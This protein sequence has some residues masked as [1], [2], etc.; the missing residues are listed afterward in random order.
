MKGD[1][2]TFPVTIDAFVGAYFPPT[3]RRRRRLAINI[4]AC[5]VD[6]LRR[7]DCASPDLVGGEICTG[8]LPSPDRISD[9]AC[10]VK[11]A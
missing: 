6:R 8:L 3:V 11:R 1:A 4:A 9:Q 7:E 2:Q 5:R 10:G